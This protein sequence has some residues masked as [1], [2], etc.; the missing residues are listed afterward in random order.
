MDGV[1]CESLCAGPCLAC[2]SAGTLGLCRALVNRDDPDL[3]SC[4][5]TCDATG[6][7]KSKR[8]QS[9]QT[10]AGGCVAGTSCADTFCCDRACNNPCE[11]C[12]V[13]PGTCSFVSGA[14]RTGH[15]ACGG[16]G[17]CAG[18]CGGVAAACTFP[19][20]QTSCGAASCTNG[21]AKA[22]VSCDGAGNCPTPTA[23]P[24]SPFICAATAC[25]ATCT[26]NTQCAT[27]AACVGTAC[28]TCP[29]GQT[30]CPNA[31]VA[32]ATDVNNCGTCGH[33][34]PGGACV[35]GV[36]Q[37]GNGAKDGTET[38]VDCGGTCTAKCAVN[39]GC[40]V[41]GDCTTGSCV[42]LFCALVTGPPNWLAGPSLNTGRGYITAPIQPL[43]SRAMLMLAVGGRD[44]A[45]PNVPPVSQS[46]EVLDTS[47][48]S[49][50]WQ[51]IGT[52]LPPGM[53]GYDEPS[54]TDASGRILVF[55]FFGIWSYTGSTL[56]RT[57]P[58]SILT[59]RDATGATRGANGLIYVVGGGDMPF[60]T[61]TRIIEAY[62][63]TTN[64]WTGGLAA[65]PTPRTNLA[66]VTGSDGR[67]YAIGG[68]TQ[69]ANGVLSIVGT[70][71]A[72][73]LSTDQWT[74]LSELPDP[75]EEIGAAAGPDGRIYT[76][77]GLSTNG[78]FL[79]TVNAYS[80][81][82]NRWSP[83]ASIGSARFGV[84]VNVA[85]DGHIWAVG[86]T[87]NPELPGFATVLV[88]GP[89][90]SVSPQAAAAGAAATVTG[91][92]FAPNATVSVFMGSTA[93]PALATGTTNAAGALTAGIRFTVP[94]L[95]G[96]EQALIVM[97]NRSQYPITLSFRVQ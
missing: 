9:C 87:T 84:G 52:V 86:G 30:V 35:S 45:D 57:V 3:A 43:T 36:C 73:N 39:K 55:S 96:G 61:P 68:L 46:Y 19:G 44:D 49:P 6:L 15:P 60:G 70:V 81:V 85:P 71:E 64:T 79:S 26:T 18:T 59:P 97:D 65:M 69:A 50:T 48:P 31:C 10:T 76:V 32:T 25:L 2:N 20:A 17:V 58:G 56:W 29:A 91:S 11:V 67:I 38:D 93:G 24:C 12:N 21:S 40:A 78:T 13:T 47:Q 7:C 14:P 95:A 8:G 28:V 62:N 80:P 77:G 83:V 94:N 51:S 22:A 54:V 5:G 53:R 82:T 89:V 23:V 63:P 74:S 75:A 1:C 34:C 92:N 27:G 72:Y 88:Y 37:C 4:P 41:N 66:A 90:V 33:V 42:R 16:T